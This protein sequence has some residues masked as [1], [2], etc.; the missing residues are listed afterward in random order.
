MKLKILVIT[1]LFPLNF[2]IAMEEDSSQLPEKDYSPEE[3]VPI[4][5]EKARAIFSKNPSFD[6]RNLI[7]EFFS[8]NPQ[9]NAPKEISEGIEYNKN[10]KSKNVVVIGAGPSGLI[11]ALALAKD[12]HTVDVYEKRSQEEF[13]LRW[14]NVSINVPDLVKRDFPEL[15]EL[16]EKQKLIQH[17]M[18]LDDPTKI[19]SYRIAIGDLQKTLAQLCN[20]FKVTIHYEGDFE[21][22]EVDAAHIV[23]LA[24]GATTFDQ[25]KPSLVEQYNFK[26]FPEYTTHGVAALYYKPE[27]D[28][29]PGLTKNRIVGNSTVNWGFKVTLVGNGLESQ[30]A[31]LATL[32]PTVTKF[33]SPS[34]NPALYWYLYA[35]KKE[36]PTTLPFSET[37]DVHSFVDF[38][39]SLATKG[40]LMH[41]GKPLIVWGDARTSAHPL[42]GAGLTIPFRSIKALLHCVRNFDTDASSLER[43]NKQTEPLARELFIKTLLVTL[44]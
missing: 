18:E 25:L 33:S 31:R 23:L 10:L 26:S 5:M 42:T 16:L 44:F 38:I 19:R 43:Y 39:P 11:A 41:E 40:A 15:D 20:S 37:V 21:P 17:E 4:V 36:Q 6:N 8:Q 34:I 30:A 14:Q 9:F 35:T 32:Y 3:L 24:T 1:L 13:A 7:S 22:K 27:T 2:L 12:G 29:Q 28:L